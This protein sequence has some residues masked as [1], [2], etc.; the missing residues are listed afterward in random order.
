MASTS[1]D[2]KP[3]R[4][5]KYTTTKHVHVAAH[6]TLSSAVRETRSTAACD[7]YSSPSA[8]ARPRPPAPAPPG[9]LLSSRPSITATAARA[10]RS[11]FPATTK[12]WQYVAVDATRHA[13]T[14]QSGKA[15]SVHTQPVNVDIICAAIEKRAL[16]SR[17]GPAAAAGA[18]S[19]SSPIQLIANK[20]T[21]V[22]PISARKRPGVLRYF[23]LCATP[24]EL[25]QAAP[26]SATVAASFSMPR[27][28]LW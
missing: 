18:P 15:Y 13:A 28:A 27:I 1:R 21:A 17:T 3:A 25:P 11:A 10:A 24:N 14:A 7:A 26:R 19:S 20:R 2:T 16:A 8:A 12:M 4:P 5:T 23:G 22:L 9:R 6:D